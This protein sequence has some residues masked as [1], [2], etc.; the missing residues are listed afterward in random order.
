M[1]PIRTLV[2]GSCDPAFSRVR[3]AFH[4]NFTAHDEVGAAVTVYVGRRE[5]VDLW[6]GWRDAA[7]C[8]PWARSTIVNAYSV[9]KGITSMLVLALVGQQRL[10]LDQKV[11]DVWPAFGANGKSEVTLREVLS[12]QA[13]LPA[14]R[15]LLADNDLGN[16]SGITDTL[17]QQAPWW[18]P[19]TA[20]GYHV[21]TF[22]FL[23][24]EAARRAAGAASFRRA[25]QEVLCQRADAE[26]YVGLPMFAHRLCADI[27]GNSAIPRDRDALANLVVPPET[28]PEQREMRNKA[29]TNPPAISGVGVVNSSWWRSIEIPSTNGH[30]T[31]RGVARLYAEALTGSLF[32]QSLLEEAC[33]TQSEG[34]DEI[35]GR[36][37]RFGLGFQLPQEHRRM[38]PGKRTFGHFGYGG[39]L[40]FGDPDSQISFAYLMN[41]PGERWQSPRSESLIDAVYASLG[42]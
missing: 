15:S 7:R 4:N 6:G 21:N 40:G 1:A 36:E 16:W 14:I 20:H 28:P 35:L 34:P 2:E 37:T 27:V 19:G 5:V 9:G 42:A 32:P 23:A 11:A 39:S 3:D 26:F 18:E 24:G 8:K 38:G 33:T 17:A 31:A 13:G 41:R 10:A 22:G 30:G 25:L 12:H 29:Y